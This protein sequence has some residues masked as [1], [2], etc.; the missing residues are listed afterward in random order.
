[1]SAANTASILP[2]GSMVTFKIHR[3]IVEKG[4]PTLFCVM[5]MC[6]FDGTYLWVEQCD[7]PWMEGTKYDALA[8]LLN[9]LLNEVAHDYR[10]VNYPDVTNV[11]TIRPPGQEPFVDSRVIKL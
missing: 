9:T 3:V 5:C 11:I 6:V 8:D 10:L 4:V 2:M 7:I 1:M